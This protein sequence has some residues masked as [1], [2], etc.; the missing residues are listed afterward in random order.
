M[1]LAGWF[2]VDLGAKDNKPLKIC[3]SFS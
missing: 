2:S 3:S 1:V